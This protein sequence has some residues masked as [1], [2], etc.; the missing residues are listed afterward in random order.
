MRVVWFA[1]S[2]GWGKLHRAAAVLRRWP[3][4]DDELV[5]CHLG[6][7]PP[8]L[9][10]WRLEGVR[11]T[12]SRD[13]TRYC[14]G[15]LLVVDGAPG[16][17]AGPLLEA[18]HAAARVAVLYRAP[19]SHAI[20]L[21]GALHIAVEPEAEQ[22]ES[23]WPVL[24]CDPTEVLTR[25]RA[26][27]VLGVADE[28]RLVLVVPSRLYNAPDLIRRVGAVAGCGRRVLALNPERHYP[29]HRY[30]AAA[31]V[32]VGLAGGRLRDECVASGLPHLLVAYGP[33]Q[34]ARATCAID[35]LHDQ[36]ERALAS[37]STT[38]ESW[39]NRAAD[40]AA[41]LVSFAG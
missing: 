35:E 40:L 24:L 34:R 29:A 32:V 31:D 19:P 30:L 10:D 5:I 37:E 12:T 7:T 25:E 38:H 9:Q 18:A 8:P 21:A 28:D 41:R 17:W 15:D 33:D 6:P 23:F 16:V 27:A 2:H 4:I 13:V 1:G 14:Y 22:G 36:T 20:D 26:R 3:R 39:I 11:I